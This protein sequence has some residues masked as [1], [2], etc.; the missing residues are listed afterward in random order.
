MV[1]RRSLSLAVFATIALV[2][3][4]TARLVDRLTAGGEL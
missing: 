4:V 2:P 1:R 3:L